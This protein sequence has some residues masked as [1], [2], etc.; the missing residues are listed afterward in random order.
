MTRDSV[1]GA[2]VTKYGY[3]PGPCLHCTRPE[4]AHPAEADPKPRDPNGPHPMPACERYTAT[5]LAVD[6]LTEQVT[7]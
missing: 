2:A 1:T 4:S 7:T 3:T 6:E 5:C